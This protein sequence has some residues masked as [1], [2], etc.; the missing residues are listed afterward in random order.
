MD[1]L[2][3]QNCTD[4]DI[5]IL[6][7]ALKARYKRPDCDVV[8]MHFDKQSREIKYTLILHPEPHEIKVHGTIG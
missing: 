2:L 3:P 5:V 7:K 6:L 4:E 1:E 8:D